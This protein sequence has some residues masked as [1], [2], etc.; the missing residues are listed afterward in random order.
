M[1]SILMV[2]VTRH[3]NKENKKDLLIENIFNR[4]EIKVIFIGKLLVINVIMCI[5]G[6]DVYWDIYDKSNLR[7]PLRSMG[8]YSRFSNV[9]MCACVV[10]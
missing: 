5:I 10:A 9:Y 3:K 7:C 8:F 1:F 6:V 2:S 4:N